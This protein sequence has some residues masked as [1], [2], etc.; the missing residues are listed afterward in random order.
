MANLTQKLQNRPKV[1]IPTQPITAATDVSKPVGKG[2][3][4]KS[5]KS[6]VKVPNNSGNSLKGPRKVA[7]GK[8]NTKQIVKRSGRVNHRKLGHM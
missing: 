4:K 7:T 8:N 2:N 3:I 5:S 1:G 6:G